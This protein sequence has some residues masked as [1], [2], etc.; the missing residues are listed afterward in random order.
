MSRNVLFLMTGSIAAYKACHVLSRLKQDGHQI[1]VV[2][3]PSALRFIGEATIEGLIDRPVR[4]ALFGTGAH[5]AHIN[6]IRWADLAIVCPATANTI[7][8]LAAGVGDDL[9]T[10]LFLA[11]DFTK[12]WLIAPAMNSKMYHHPV[13]RSSVTKLKD[14][15]CSILETASGVLACGEIG[16]GKLLEPTLILEEIKKHLAQ[17]PSKPH[18]SPSNKHASPGHGL[19]VLITSGGTVEPID[20]V[21]SI[22]NTSTGSTGA[23]IADAFLGSG[24]RVTFLQARGSVGPRAE[25]LD[26]LNRFHPKLFSS[27]R[28]LDELLQMEL[29]TSS[30]DVIIHAA[31]VSDF[32]L[33]QAHHKLSS[34][35]EQLTLHLKRNPKLIDSLRAWSK[36][37][38]ATLIGFKLTADPSTQ[39]EKIEKLMTRAKPDYIVANDMATL[40][41][42]SIHDSEKEVSSGS[43]REALAFTLLSLAES[44]RRE[45]KD[46]L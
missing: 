35:T 30:Y 29:K 26:A 43:T 2:A 4:K 39:H 44:G 3:S 41:S 42:W 11:H 31:A 9:I 20:A 14:M 27:F 8:K 18:A 40:P 25:E 19:N 34:E 22:T 6:L 33:D 37:T 5:M 28:D 23:L 32:S 46:L 38:K 17:T 1:E 10:T 12:P 45:T 15:G 16:D 7:N 21:R 36:N 13:T 24:H